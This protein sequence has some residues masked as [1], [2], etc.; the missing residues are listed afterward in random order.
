MPPAPSGRNNK[1]SAKDDCEIYVGNINAQTPVE[2]ED[3][4]RLFEIA[5]QVNNVRIEKSNAKDTHFAFITFSTVDEAEQGCLYDGFKYHALS[6][7]VQRKGRPGPPRLASPPSDEFTRRLRELQEQENTDLYLTNLNTADASEEV[8]H[9]TFSAFGDVRRV[10]LHGDPC[11]P[12]RPAFITFSRPEQVQRAVDAMDGKEFLGNTLGVCKARVGQRFW[13]IEA[14]NKKTDDDRKEKN[15]E[16]KKRQPRNEKSEQKTEKTADGKTEPT[17]SNGKR[18]STGREDDKKGISAATTPTDDK[19]TTDGTKASN[20]TAAKTSPPGAPAAKTA[21]PASASGATKPS[22][23]PASQKTS[24][25]SLSAPPVDPTEPKEVITAILKGLSNTRTSDKE[26]SISTYCSTDSHGVPTMVL[27]P[28]GERVC[29]AIHVVADSIRAQLDTLLEQQAA[30]QQ[31]LEESRNQ[32]SEVHQ[33]A[34]HL[35]RSHQDALNELLRLKTQCEQLASLRITNLKPDITSKEVSALCSP[36]GR[37]QHAVVLGTTAHVTFCSPVNLQDVAMQ[38]SSQTGG[39]KAEA[40]FTTSTV[41]SDMSNGFPQPLTSDQNHESDALGIAAG[42]PHLP[43]AG[44]GLNPHASAYKGP[45]GS[46]P[47]RKQPPSQVATL[48]RN[49]PGLGENKHGQRQ[50]P[51]QQHLSQPQ[52]QQQ[53]AP[54]PKPQSP[55]PSPAAPV[56]QPLT[57]GK[58][59][60]QEGICIV[61]SNVGLQVCSVCMATYYCGSDCQMSHWPDHMNECEQLK[62][63]RR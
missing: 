1:D 40:C 2:P 54:Q 17:N 24:P 59:A 11:N 62:A 33:E 25:P 19:K 35:H 16:T 63:K 58:R 6:L 23:T 14:A 3:L 42:F 20:T 44:S 12:S 8:L 52:Q 45:P 37:V 29:N 13:A 32:L 27:P 60:P 26:K 48:V 51:Q 49:P 21:R 56:A 10:H 5:G 61:C 53:Q 34:A 36:Y 41:I 38:L 55:S 9:D 46:A 18:K 22:T 43:L 50:S 28:A 39:H 30:L 4:K 47:N 31:E 15:S 7:K 57:D